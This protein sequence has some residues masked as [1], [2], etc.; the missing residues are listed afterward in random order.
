MDCNI[1]TTRPNNRSTL[2]RRHALVTLA[3][4]PLVAPLAGALAQ[5]SKEGAPTPAQTLGPFYP[6]SA[7]ERP[8][9]VDPDLIVVD[10]TQVV[11]KGM[12]LYLTGRVLAR[13]G[14]PVTQA[15]VEIWQCDANAV[16]HHPAGGDE[17][18]RD[19][20]FQG[21][22]QTRTDESGTFHFRTIKPVP[23]PGRTAHIHVRIQANSQS[24]LATQLYLPDE[25]DNDRDVI[26]RHLTVAERAQVALLLK[27]TSSPHPL[28]QATR[29]M[30]SV[31]LT[32]A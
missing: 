17:G 13:G 1:M 29:V 30:A 9:D 12:P 7:A 22:G 28:A 18:Q 10:G 3:A 5:S 14:K 8:K 27:P 32:L 15:L 23:Y 25:P 20:A 26:Y 21:Y 16:Y 19:P 2:A 24:S 11:T 4:A 6:R 31:D